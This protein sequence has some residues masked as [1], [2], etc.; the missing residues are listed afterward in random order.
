MGRWVGRWVGRWI[1]RSIEGQRRM[2]REKREREK[3]VLHVCAAL[4]HPTPQ[5]THN[6]SRARG[7]EVL[8]WRRRACKEAESAQGPASSA[9]GHTKKK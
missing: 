9:Q 3:F 2:A 4:T 7:T 1:G 6:R 8:R 5:N